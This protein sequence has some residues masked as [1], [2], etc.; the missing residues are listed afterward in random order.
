MSGSPSGHSN[1]YLLVGFARSTSTLSPFVEAQAR[2]LGACAAEL[3]PP[4]FRE[5]AANS[6]AAVAAR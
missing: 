6:P 3:G 4:T 5:G 1:A 2:L